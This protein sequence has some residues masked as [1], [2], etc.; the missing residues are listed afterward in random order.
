MSED[1]AAAAPA[2]EP[3]TVAQSTQAAPVPST[4]APPPPGAAGASEPRREIAES[5]A[6][7]AA[8]KA[9]DRRADLADASAPRGVV[10]NAAAAVAVD[11]AILERRRLAQVQS[12]PTPTPTPLP[13]S[14]VLKKAA[15]DS[16]SRDAV[17]PLEQVV[18]GAAASAERSARRAAFAAGPALVVAAADSTAT[19]APYA[20]CYVDPAAGLTFRLTTIDSARAVGGIGAWRVAPDSTIEVRWSQGGGGFVFRGRGTRDLLAGQLTRPGGVANVV[21]LRREACR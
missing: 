10:A 15:P 4:P 6:R 11:S 20:G 1:R 8:P 18:A 9:S 3:P 21:Q 17:K 7:T 16:S 2:V 19:T 14:V 13:P 12:I 5:R